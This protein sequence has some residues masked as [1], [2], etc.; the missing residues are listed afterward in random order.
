MNLSMVWGEGSWTGVGGRGT[1]ESESGECISIE[2]R[3]GTERSVA[4]RSSE[5]ES[6]NDVW[7]GRANVTG[8]P[9]GV[10]REMGNV[11]GGGN[12]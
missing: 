9:S 11:A 4:V 10:V 3:D 7:K 2:P 6:I 8:T 1:N 12:G 5:L